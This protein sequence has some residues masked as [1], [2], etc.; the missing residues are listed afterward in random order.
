MTATPRYATPVDTAVHGE[1]RFT[2]RPDDP[3]PLYRY[4][5]RIST[6]GSTPFPAE[7]GRYHLYA[8]WFCPWSQRA[9]IQ[10][11]LHGLDDVVS[12][13]YVDNVR[14]G[15]GWAFREGTGA[16]PVNGFT[17]LREAFEATEPGFDGHVSVPV[18]WDREGHRVVSND[19]ATIDA[20]L[21]TQFARWDNGVDSYPEV[22]RPAIDA[23]D[24][25]LGPTVNQGVTAAA[26][27]GPVGASARARLLR[28]FVD[29]DR[30]LAD[31]PFLLGDRLTLADVRLWVS[32]VRI[33]PATELAIGTRL[34]D[35]P[36]LWAYAQALYRRPPFRDTT[37]F[38]TFTAA[39]DP[40]AAWAA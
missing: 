30:R 26:A 6:D 18:L 13:S 32:L 1:Y 35:Y 25:W 28:A 15:R 37:D 33:D 21:A 36:H 29:L 31:Q 4:S 2:R 7:P 23:V 11:L 10:R 9:T 17:L 38:S 14:D 22:L 39:S 19:Y 40:S 5:G 3:R 24:G 34:P 12:V 27:S 16:D 8:G 20:D